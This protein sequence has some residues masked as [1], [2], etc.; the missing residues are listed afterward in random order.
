MH[1]ELLEDAWLFLLVLEFLD[2]PDRGPTA[3]L[4]VVLDSGL[5]VEVEED[6][7]KTFGQESCCVDVNSKNQEESRISGTGQR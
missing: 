6:I 7:S 5:E 4:G 2:L 1:L 3:T